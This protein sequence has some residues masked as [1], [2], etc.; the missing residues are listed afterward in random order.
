[1]NRKITVKCP[2]CNND[3]EI[4]SSHKNRN[5]KCK[6]CRNNKGTRLYRIWEN[7]KSRCNNKNVPNYSIYGAKGIKVCDEWNK[8]INFK[9]WAV[10]NGYSDNLTLERI[11]FNK[12]YNPENCKWATYYEQSRNKR[13]NVMVEI[14]SETMCLK[15]W[16]KKLNIDYK[17]IHRKLKSLNMTP[18]EY[19]ST[20]IET[21]QTEGMAD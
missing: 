18:K 20:K 11:D 4:W 13:N 10:N 5:S 1:M 17:N 14:N 8:F 2:L 21:Y 9:T 3:F 16:C 15:D 19:L 12:G 7:M 6:D